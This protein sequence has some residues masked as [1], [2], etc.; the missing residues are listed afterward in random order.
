MEGTEGGAGIGISHG[1]PPIPNSYKILRLIIIIII[2]II[3]QIHSFLK[4]LMW[5]RFYDF[6][7]FVMRNH[8]KKLSIYTSVKK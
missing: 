6:L 3:R 4:N 1:P 5:V 7:K 8:Y 2:I